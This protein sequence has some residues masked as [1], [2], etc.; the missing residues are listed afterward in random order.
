[1]HSVVIACI[2]FNNRCSEFIDSQL[3]VKQGDPSS[4]M[5]FMMFLNDINQFIN[6][7]LDGIFMV[8]DIKLFL[9]LYADDQVIFAKSPEALQAMLLD[10][11]NYCNIWGL[12][13]NTTKTK[14]MIFEKGRHTSYD[15]YLNNTKLEIVTTFKYLG[16]YF[17]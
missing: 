9:L 3:G 11:E 4:P 1:M 16:V 2:R 8:D 7:D 13:I 12:K 5:L 14:T 17:F 10:L 15:F 6:A